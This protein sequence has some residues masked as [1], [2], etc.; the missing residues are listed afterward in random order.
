MLRAPIILP[1]SVRLT[2]PL[3]KYMP[4]TRLQVGSMYAPWYSTDN[5]SAFAKAAV[6]MTSDRQLPDLAANACEAFRVIAAS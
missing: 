2:C 6:M 3:R 4:P 1:P 5:P